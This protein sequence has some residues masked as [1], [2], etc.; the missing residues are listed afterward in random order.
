[1]NEATTKSFYDESY[2]A[3]QKDVGAFGG[4]SNK[5]KFQEFI[6]ENDKVIDFGCGGGFLLRN[7]NCKERLG[8]E[9]NPVAR[10]N[11]KKLGIQVSAGAEEVPDGWADVIVSNHALEHTE[12]PLAE[13]RK[14]YPKL[15]SGG[16]IVF[17]VPCDALGMKY[18]AD[19]KHRHL[20]SWS[21]MN[22]GHL[23][24]E[25]G[26]QV[27]DSHPFRHKWPRGYQKI[28]GLF[29]WSVFHLIARLYDRVDTTWSQVRVIARKP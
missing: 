13:L 28:V 11:A 25:A 24:T 16:K 8:I 3:W 12:H 22:L 2:F 21:P 27:L 19:N 5:I 29:G 20:Y 15:K 10:E 18:K 4:L 6:S 1:M 26:F 7:L 9:V 17:V 23:F 14:L